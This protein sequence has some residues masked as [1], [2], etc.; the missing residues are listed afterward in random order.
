MTGDSG[1]AKSAL[2]AATVNE[3]KRRGMKAIFITMVDLLDELRKGFNPDSD[4]NFDDRWELLR[5]VDVLCIDE[6]DKFNSKPWA[7]ERFDALVNDRWRYLEERLTLMACNNL[8][9]LQPHIISRMEDGRG[10]IFRM[11]GED[12]RPKLR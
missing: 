12:F 11:Q 5:S 10:R 4:M 9:G 6:V 1:I 3:C 8:R 2:M 7:K